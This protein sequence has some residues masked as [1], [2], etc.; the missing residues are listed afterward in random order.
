M[1]RKRK[2]VEEEPRVERRDLPDPNDVRDPR[3]GDPEHDAERR[4]PDAGT[5][6]PV[7]IGGAPPADPD[8]P[9]PSKHA[10]PQK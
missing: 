4:E 5:G 7:R 6:R 3:K 2:R 1:G 10:P 8:W 9:E